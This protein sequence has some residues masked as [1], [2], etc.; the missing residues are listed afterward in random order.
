MQKFKVVDEIIPEPL[1]GAH[2][3]PDS[4][5]LELSN[6]LEKTLSDLN[7]LDK[8]EIQKQKENKYIKLHEF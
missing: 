3:D 8:N 7:H 4:A 1:G 6:V 2:R 5:I